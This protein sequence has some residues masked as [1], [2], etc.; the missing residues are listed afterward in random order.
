MGGGDRCNLHSPGCPEESEDR[1]ENCG[2]GGPPDEWAAVGQQKQVWL[3]MHRWW[4][5]R[6]SHEAFGSIHTHTVCH[7]LYLMQA[8]DRPEAPTGAD[9]G[10]RSRRDH[11]HGSLLSSST[12]KGAGSPHPK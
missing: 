2:G 12:E 3:L 7:V 6:G 10:R 11:R 5:V 9:W 1:C 8:C 4:I